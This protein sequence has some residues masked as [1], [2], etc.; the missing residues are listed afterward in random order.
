M[1]SANATWQLW[2]E[3]WGLFQSAGVG[4]GRGLPGAIAASLPGSEFAQP[5]P[6]AF[7]LGPAKGNRART[8]L[9]LSP[10]PFVLYSIGT[11]RFG[12]FS[13]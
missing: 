8:R 9:A 10:R 6:P 4:G 11:S 5:V 12:G 3:D 7:E 13:W 2:L 1:S